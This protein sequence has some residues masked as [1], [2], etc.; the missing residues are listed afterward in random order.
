[1]PGSLL[2]HLGASRQSDIEFH[3]HFHRTTNQKQLYETM[4]IITKTFPIP[5]F[6][7]Q[8]VEKLKSMS[9]DWRQ[10]SAG[11]MFDGCVGAF[12]GYRI[13]IEDIQTLSQQEKGFQSTKVSLS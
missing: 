6:S 7:F 12:D 2:K 5:D 9:A 4:K 10:R 8:D 11:E 13:P 3:Y 1:M